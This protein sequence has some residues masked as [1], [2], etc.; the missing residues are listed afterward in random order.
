MVKLSVIIPIYNSEYLDECLDNIINQTLKDIEI[1]CVDNSINSY[2]ILKEYKNK[3]NRVKIIKQNKGI[4]KGIK[5]SQGEYVCFLDSNDKLSTDSLKYIYEILSK[6]E[7]NVDLSRNS[8]YR[9]IYNYR[10]NCF[11]ELIDYFIEK[12]G[13]IPKSIQYTIIYYIKYFEN[14]QDFPKEMD[15]EEINKFWDNLYNILDYIDNEIIINN[16]I[17]EN[18]YFSKFLIYIK[19]RKNF[20]IETSKNEIYL[21]T[22][23]Y[24]INNLKN[25]KIYFDIIELKDN[26]L[27]I[28]GNF[29]SSCSNDVLYA[30]ATKINNGKKEKYKGKYIEYPNT[31][32]EI[33]RYL[34]I[35]W[36]FNY[37]FEFKIPINK[38]TE[39]KI[40]IYMVY[41]ENGEK[42][43]IKSRFGFRG[44][45]EINDYSHYYIKNSQILAYIN[46]SFNIIP[47]KYSKSLRLELSAFKKILRSNKKNKFSSI[48]YRLLYLLF[49]PKMKNKQIYL[50]MDRRD[51]TGDNG[52]HLFRYAIN[53]KDNISKY[54]T[55]EKGCKQ[56][57][58]LKKEYG[59]NILEFGSFKHKFIYM[60]TDKFIGSQGYKSHINPFSDK[61]LRL[62]QGI[63]SPPVY[64]LQHGVVRYNRTN[65]LR[66][67]DINFSLL[68]SVSDLEYNAFVEKYN[69]DKEII[70]ELGYP[71]YDNLTKENLKKEVVIIPTWRQLIKTEED[72]LNSEYYKRWNNLL[73]N[74]ELLEFAKEKGYNIIYKP[75]PNS[76]KFLD[77]FNTSKVVVDTKRRFHDI[78]C[79]SALMITDYSSVHFDFAYLK[80]PIIYYQYGIASLDIPE[81]GELAIDEDAS[82]FGE[83]IKDEEILINKI[84]E[85]II[86]D[87]KMEEE[88]KNRATN[89]F[90]F[91]DK[92]NCKRVYNW[93]LKH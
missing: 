43:H 83:I 61:N 71:R 44:F 58:Q 93:I 80:K 3:D 69:Y 82:T 92:N 10:L 88:Y 50:F 75:H 22:N 91:N 47:Y 77:L 12:E 65:W 21:K 41:E 46:N 36:K 30:E 59:N 81:L 86:N 57:K 78:L 5:I 90:K 34:G 29:I 26:V 48:F 73:N 55:V 70:Q 63:S 49:L 76:I 19:N 53:Q 62:V 31:S 11:K 13:E 87:C 68:L 2:N 60:F 74:N 23:D 35:D 89:F 8:Y 24:I 20:K 1:I 56:F 16:P 33:N 37:N 39:N 7:I 14:I 45:A 32:R 85:Y 6:Y 40:N 38:K 25:H 4:N 52:E 15:K 28:S 9:D 79:E 51:N 42:I 67:Y 17:I 66:K 64:F 72:L 18:K 54:F 27:N 84:K